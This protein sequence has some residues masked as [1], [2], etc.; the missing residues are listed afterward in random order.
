MPEKLTL[1]KISAAVVAAVAIIMCLYQLA[2]TQVLIFEPALHIVLH[3]G[4]AM[5]VI[6]LDIFHNRAQE[7]KNPWFS[8]SLVSE[9]GVVRVREDQFDQ[10]RKLVADFEQRAP[11]EGSI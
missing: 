7:G 3:V 1:P 11:D 4:F 10:A 6:F 9:T 8:L 2:V 5:V